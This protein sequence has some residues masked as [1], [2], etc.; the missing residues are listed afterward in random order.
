MWLMVSDR[1]PVDWV[2]LV[3]LI[4]IEH[5][6]EKVGPWILYEYNNAAKIIG[7][8][9]LLVTNLCQ[10]ITSTAESLGEPIFFKWTCKSVSELYRPD[11]LIVLD[12]LA[13]SRLEPGDSS[14]K[15]AAVIGGILGDHP[16]RGRTR[17]LLTSRLKGALVRNLGD[18]QLTIDGASIVA[19]MV[20]N[21]GRPLESI[22]F[23]DGI[24]LR[25]KLGVFEHEIVLPYRYPV[26][27]DSGKPIVSE[28]LLRYLERGI[29]YDEHKLL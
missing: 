6:E 7:F 26:L 11:R 20:L 12:P 5:L 10:D 17:T 21:V 27:E 19:H 1:Y 29:E 23:V 3:V 18:K 24:R 9:N 8:E 14:N 4:V 16:P 2:I 15:S 22:K 28:K 25:R 13:P